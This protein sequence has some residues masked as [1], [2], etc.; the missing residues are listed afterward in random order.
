MKEENTQE[1]YTSMEKVWPDHSY[2][3]DF[4]HNHIINFVEDT[5]KTKLLESSIYLNAGSGGSE[6]NL[7]GSCYHLDIAENLIDKFPNY[8]VS[9]IEKM[10]FE[11]NTFDA[12]ICVG[13]VINYCSALESIC[14]LSRILKPGG[15]LVL[16]FERSNTAELW[17]NS[18]YGKIATLQNY[19]YLGHTHS[20]WL[21]SE[22]YIKLLLSKNGLSIKKQKRF[23]NLSALINRITKNEELAGKFTKFDSLFLPVSYLMSH[24]TILLC[25]KNY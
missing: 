23:H 14:E 22:K 6:Y 13:S 18:E 7:S 12:I 16:E 2:W 20:L 21:Y 19:E 10:P 17:L 25:E 5:L 11:H 15:F 9:S 4:T 24:N 1:I 8:F 3:Y